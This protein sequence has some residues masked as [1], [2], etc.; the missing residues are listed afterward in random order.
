KKPAAAADRAA[1]P[2]TSPDNGPPVTRR[3]L[4]AMPR[5]AVPGKHRGCVRPFFRFH[6]RSLTRDPCAVRERRLSIQRKTL[7]LPRHGEA[8]CLEVAD[9]PLIPEKPIR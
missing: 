6:R 2:E 5:G 3:P 4:G 1:Q 8:P 9:R 7:S